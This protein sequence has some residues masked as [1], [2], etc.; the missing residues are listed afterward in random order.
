[1]VGADA[2]GAAERSAAQDE[3]GECF[4]EA[5]ELGVVVAVGVF[6]HREF[7]FV[8]VITGIDADFFYVFDGFHGSAREKMDVGDEGNVGETGGG[9]LGADGAQAFCGGNVGRG[10]TDDFATDLSQG[11][12]LLDGGGDVLGVAGRHRL[13]TDRVAAANADTADIDG[14]G[15]TADGV[16]AGSAVGHDESVGGRRTKV[17]WRTCA[18]GCGGEARGSRAGRPGTGKE[19][20]CRRGREAGWARGR[21]RG[22]GARILNRGPSAS[23]RRSSRRRSVTSK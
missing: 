3:R 10:D 16:V 21:R 17:Q 8:G 18:E 1:M 2:H 6:A 4:V 14:M 22:W 12:G 15:V 5:G 11:D 7:L 23:R 19:I 20:T 13:D 9:E